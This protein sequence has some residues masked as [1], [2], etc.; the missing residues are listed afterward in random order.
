MLH[1]LCAFAKKPLFHAFLIG[2]FG[3]MAPKIIEIVPKLLENVFPTTGHYVAFTL[4]GMMGGI[5]VIVYKEVNLQKALVLGAG[6]PALIAALTTQAIGPKTTETQALIH[7]FSISIMAE[8]YA[9]EPSR[10]DNVRMIFEQNQSPYELN[11]LW[12]RADGKTI[13]QYWKTG[14]TLIVKVPQGTKEIRLDFPNRSKGEGMVIPLS[15]FGAS[16]TIRLRIVNQKDKQGFW[17]TFGNVSV[18]EYSIER[19]VREKQ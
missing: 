14:D 1:W 4:L 8:A 16:G 12:I 19:A 6:A 11:K 9:Q 15:S 3:G 17:Q 10:T 5:I 18:P 7:P 13:G 2:A